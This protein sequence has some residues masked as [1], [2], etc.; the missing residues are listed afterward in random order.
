M[1]ATLQQFWSYLLGK[2]SEIKDLDL[3]DAVM[4]KVILKIHRTR[5]DKALIRVP[6]HDVVQLHK[7]DRE[8][9]MAATQKRIDTLNEHKAEI[10]TDPVLTVERLNAYL[11]SV[12]GVKVVQESA[13]SYIAYE[14]NGRL[15]AL[16]AVFGES[17]GVELEVE[18]YT[19]KNPAKVLKGL[20]RV[21]RMNGFID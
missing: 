6:L 11:P 12:S 9:S 14:G 15:A 5:I 8:N 19:F 2:R 13:R 3:K 10:L 7:L 4:A 1:L 18:E 17:D 16:Q 21:R 20:N